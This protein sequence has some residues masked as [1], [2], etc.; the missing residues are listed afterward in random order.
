MLWL[1]AGSDDLESCRRG[2]G[3]YST[4]GQCISSLGSADSAYSS[5][6]VEA[7]LAVV[8]AEKSAREWQ[9]PAPAGLTR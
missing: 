6:D 9:V 1:A 2:A 8:A 3:E 7:A 5:H 4:S